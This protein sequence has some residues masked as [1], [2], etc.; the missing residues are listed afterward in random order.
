MPTPAYIFSTLDDEPISPSL[1][2]FQTKSTSVMDHQNTSTTLRTSVKKPTAEDELEELEL[3]SF[4]SDKKKPRDFYKEDEQESQTLNK[5]DYGNFTLL[6]V[7]CK[8]THWHFQTMTNRKLLI[9]N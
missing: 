4:T 6:V 1:S 7:L 2:D 3:D 5:R 9:F 8:K